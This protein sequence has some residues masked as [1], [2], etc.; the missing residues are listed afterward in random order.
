[1]TEK[2]SFDDLS[3]ELQDFL[4]FADFYTIDSDGYVYDPHYK[5]YPSEEQIREQ[6]E[7]QEGDSR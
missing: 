7:Y 6:I 5:E 3:K 1:M 4:K 2:V